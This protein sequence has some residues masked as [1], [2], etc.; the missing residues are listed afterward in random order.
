M[1]TIDRGSLLG[2]CLLAAALALG[3]GGSGTPPPP[4]PPSNHVPDV[5]AGVAATVVMIGASTQA[6]ATATDAD[7]DT[8]TYSW[9]QTSP[10][11]PQGSFSAPGVATSTWTAPTVAQVTKFT[12][13]VTVSDGKGG[14]KT[15]ST[16]VYVKAS[17]DTSFV[18]EVVPILEPCATCHQGPSGLGGVLS[19]EADKAYD[20]LVNVP[21][22]SSCAPELRVAPGDPD[23]SVLFL[24][25]A[26]TTCGN[27]M[28]PA[29]PTFFDGHP[30][31]L[32][33]IRSWIQQGAQ[34]N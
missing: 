13:A 3:C 22:R 11:S 33:A 12:L 14:T 5:T 4:P 27:R 31:Q 24:K 25:I 20:Q 2:G 30:D 29:T 6:S 7:N 16:T 26:G 21:A 9:A 8:L 17:T 15:A 10:A 18:A 23:A 34:H 32:E 28:P 19:L 1:T